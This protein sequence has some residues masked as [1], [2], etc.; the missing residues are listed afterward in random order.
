VR[1]LVRVV[2][3]VGV[4]PASAPTLADGVLLWDGFAAAHIHA[5][6]HP[7]STFPQFYR[8][9]VASRRRHF[10]LFEVYKRSED[11]ENPVIE[12]WPDFDLDVP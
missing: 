8:Q 1:F 12:V 7:H 6:F 4:G 5:L 10:D 11:S 2:G 3:R 9:A